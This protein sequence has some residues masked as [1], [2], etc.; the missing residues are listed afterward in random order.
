MPAS[1]PV[2]NP[3]GPAIPPYDRPPERARGGEALAAGRRRNQLVVAEIVAV[4]LIVAA[5][6]G[7]PLLLVGV[8][9]AVA[10]TVLG[11]GRWRRRWVYQWLGVALRYATR[12]RLTND[13]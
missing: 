11:F 7:V 1:P 6:S 8:P 3:H 12:P 9:I 4:T 2:D 10:L 13:L 5:T